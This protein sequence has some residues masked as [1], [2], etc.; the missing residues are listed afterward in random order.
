LAAAVQ[1]QSSAARPDT[2]L[3][4]YW[5]S[6]KLFI[7]KNST[8]HCNYNYLIIENKQNQQ[9]G[10]SVVYLCKTVSHSNQDFTHSR[11]I[12]TLT[13]FTQCKQPRRGSH[14]I[15]SNHR[16]HCLAD[17]YNRDDKKQ[18]QQQFLTAPALTSGRG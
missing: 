3:L 15:R 18:Q 4:I 17:T 16:R 2:L 9:S 11:H 7:K 14:V 12:L 6:A 1:L 8:E 5:K 10:S 13:E